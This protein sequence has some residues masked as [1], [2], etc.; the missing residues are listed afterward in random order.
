MPPEP[1]EPLRFER[2]CLA[3]PWGGRR[4]A[5]LLGV[6]LPEG[7]IGETWELVDRERENSKVAEGPHQ[8]RT[9]RELL[10]ADG[11][12]HLGRTRRSPAGEFPLLVKFL[13]AQEDLSVQVHPHDEAAARLPR[14]DAPKT[15]C[16]YILE[17]RPG[18]V[19]YLGLRPGVDRAAF[20]AA[21]GTP[22]V[23][24]LLERHSVRAGQFFFVPGGTVHAI[25]A[26]VAL[27]EV[28]Q[29]S[30][31]TYRIYDWGRLEP[32]GRPRPVHLR[33]ALDV[34][35]FGLAPNAALEPELKAC[36]D[37]SRRAAL[38]DC[39]SFALELC[40]VDAQA[41]FQTLGRA[42]LQ[43]VLAGRGE[44]VLAGSPRRS[45]LSPGDTWL[46]PAECGSYRIEAHSPLRVLH[47]DTK[48]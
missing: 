33:E 40:E 24:D 8:G 44:L 46:V 22:A 15:E 23:V 18:S 35:R 32:D 5:S 27:A 29:T 42:R 28:Q 41:S 30:D 19:I 7:R 31:T 37:G 4:L 2:L 10:R 20:A 9:L 26:G 16:W 1:V 25:G 38:V 13:D 17:A 45:R 12:R 14:G 3:K 6:S 11:P 48:E 39:P 47:V 21:V 43:V 34:T 36:A